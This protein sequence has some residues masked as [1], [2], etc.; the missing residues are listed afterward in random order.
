MRIL[1]LLA[2]CYTVFLISCNNNEKVLVIKNDPASKNWIGV[3]K[4]TMFQNEGTLEIYSISS[5]TI[6][7][8]LSAFS[9]G[10]TGEVED[11]ARVTNGVATF[12]QIDDN[13][14]CKITFTLKSDSV[15]IIE[16]LFGICQAA[17]GVDYSGEYKNIQKI[18]REN[19]VKPTLL[20]LNV[21]KLK[22]QDDELRNLVG[23]NMYLNYINSSQLIND[24]IKDIDSLNCQVIA[25]GVRGLFTFMENIIMIDT[26][27]NIWT[28]VINPDDDKVYYY[29]NSQKFKDHLPKTIE[30]WREKFIEKEVVYK[31]KF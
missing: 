16:Q 31:F 13:D 14:S 25:T 17:M 19:I 3:W 2:F 20:T 27:N 12:I 10:H 23:E 28:A 4:R 6:K 26:S 24:E 29:T 5:D 18:Q 7:F 30:K 11:I 9:G 8:K 22:E 1:F 15:V 21:L